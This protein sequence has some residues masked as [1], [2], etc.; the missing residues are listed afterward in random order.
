[1]L[2]FARAAQSDTKT[3]PQPLPKALQALSCPCEQHPGKGP[4]KR[5]PAVPSAGTELGMTA[6]PSI[7]CCSCE[8][9]LRALESASKTF[10]SILLLQGFN[11]KCIA[12]LA[13]AGASL[14]PRKH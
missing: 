3:P 9:S 12:W 11:D 8:L 2:S 1:M 5:I 7:S 4:G 6:P 10:F 13:G 14:L